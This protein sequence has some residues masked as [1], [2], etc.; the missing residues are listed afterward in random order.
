MVKLGWGCME[1][2]TLIGVFGGK[3]QCHYPERGPTEYVIL[4]LVVQMAAGEPRNRANWG[5]G[6]G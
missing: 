4:V 6:L 1:K 2:K 3:C 5:S